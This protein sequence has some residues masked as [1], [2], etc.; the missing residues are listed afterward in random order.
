MSSLTVAGPWLSKAQGGTNKSSN[1][2]VMSRSENRAKG[3]KNL[4]EPK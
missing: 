1:A 3:T 2:V 4:D